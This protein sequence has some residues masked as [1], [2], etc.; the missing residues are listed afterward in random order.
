MKGNSTSGNL[1]A[2][3]EG[4]EESTNDGRSA[5]VQNTQ[6]S[7][8]NY[9]DR[10]FET[11]RK[12]T[13][14]VSNTADPQLLAE[15]SPQPIEKSPPQKKNKLESR[16]KT[17]VDSA[18]TEWLSMKKEKQSKQEDADLLFLKSLLPDIKKLDERRK[19]VYKVKMISV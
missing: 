18:F 3:S 6:V 8:E 4:E 1:T 13:S 17:D 19:R 2:P 11:S 7:D 14:P 16:P 5:E 9:C 12:V 15:D 10:E